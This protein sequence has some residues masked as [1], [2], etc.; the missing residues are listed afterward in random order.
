[1]SSDNFLTDEEKNEKILN[2]LRSSHE[3]LPPNPDF[4][5]NVMA[6]AEE[7]GLLNASPIQPI[8]EQHAF[9]LPRI[10]AFLSSSTSWKGLAFVEAAGI[11]LVIATYLLGWFPFSQPSTLQRIVKHQN[12]Y[13]EENTKLYNQG[14][15]AAIRRDYSE[16]FRL[17]EQSAKSGDDRSEF[18]L[19]QMFFEGK[20]V[21]KDIKESIRLLRSAAYKGNITAQLRLVECRY[22]RELIPGEYVSDAKAYE[23]ALIW[24]NEI[25]DTESFNNSLVLFLKGMH[26]QELAAGLFE[27]SIRLHEL[28]A[29][30]DLYL[31]YAWAGIA[32]YLGMNLEQDY[33]KSAYWLQQI[34]NISPQQI[35][36]QVDI[37]I[38]RL[39]FIPNIYDIKGD[40]FSG[41]D[42]I[43]NIK[44]VVPM[45]LALLGIMYSEGLGVEEDA[46]KAFE[47]FARVAD[48]NFS[49]GKLFLAFSH[50]GGWGT[51]QD[52][53]KAYSILMDMPNDPVSQLLLAIMYFKGHGVEK[54]KEKAENLLRQSADN[55]F[56][57]AK[58]I[59]KKIQEGEYENVVSASPESSL[60]STIFAKGFV[61]GLFS[62]LYK[63]G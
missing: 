44:D 10:R 34:A 57:Y 46:S 39:Q 35:E 4:V 59:L 56:L 20:G 16:A 28:S 62:N 31:A 11:A 41:G 6:K 17:F 53:T 40:Y 1:M 60:I 33:E 9:F 55:G 14:V 43:S 5:A 18:A 23:T 52:Y 13:S 12:E 32:Y 37:L 24:L 38:S 45:S 63:R 22:C 49:Y 51:K 30:S 27:E 54:D 36:A 8:E 15:E 7:R 50:Y 21:D 42:L 29:R 19:S 61:R 47:L 25:P 2:T 58:T 3:D 48:Y 26:Y